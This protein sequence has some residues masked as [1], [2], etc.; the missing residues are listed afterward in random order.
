MIITIEIT[1]FAMVPEYTG[2]R[3]FHGIVD[4]T[5][6]ID[7]VKTSGEWYACM[8]EITARFPALEFIASWDNNVCTLESFEKSFYTEDSK[9]PLFYKIAS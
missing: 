5:M 7:N 6:I 4:C 8:E 1:H 9:S 2:N 3:P